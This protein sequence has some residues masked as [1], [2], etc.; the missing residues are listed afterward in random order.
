MSPATTSARVRPVTQSELDY[1]AWTVEALRSVWER[2]H[3][4]VFERVALVEQAL[5]ALGEDRLDPE[6]RGDA[7]RAAHMLAGSI[8][9]FG[10]LDAGDAARELESQL[11]HAT[12][13]RT[14]KLLALL[15]R[16]REGIRGP[17]T[18]CTDELEATKRSR[19]ASR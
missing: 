15:G 6:L 10:F 3:T 9:M 14:N 4:R 12:A 7:Q 18:L 2:Q 17:V 19:V 16:V 11:A 5:T 1:V 8:G 13:D